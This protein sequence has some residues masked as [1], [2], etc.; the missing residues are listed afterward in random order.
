LGTENRNPRSYGLDSMSAK[1]IVRLMNEEEHAVMRALQAAEDA[2]AE[3]AIRVAE[4]FKQ[5]GRVI[6][7]GAGTSGRIATMDA[8]EMPPTFGI[9]SD[10]F[11][12]LVSGGHLAAERSI[13]DAEDDA[14]ASVHALNELRLNQKD[15]V[16]GI[17]ASGTTPYVL[18]GVRHARQKGVWVAG[19]A[20]NPRS[21]LLELVDLPILLDTGPEVLTG[22]TRLK[23]GSAQKLALNRISTAAMVLCGKVVENLMVDVK[24]KNQK[25]KERC[26][27]IVRELTNATEDEAWDLLEKN[28]WSIRAVL[29][30]LKTAPAGV[31]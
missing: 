3:A 17:T 13:E 23:A 28:E 22:S 20:N 14:L 15:V 7:L 30:Q 24:A 25:L 6:Y 4:A 21:P 12:A 10:R 27:R 1:E 16:I 18:S 11:V 9:E 19:I 26:A 29:T 5:G 31:Q 8:A 2:I